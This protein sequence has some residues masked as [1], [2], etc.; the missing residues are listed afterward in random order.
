MYYRDFALQLNNSTSR[1]EMAGLLGVGLGMEAV[2]VF[3]RKLN[4][5]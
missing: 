5:S 2:E 3:R 1:L 4:E